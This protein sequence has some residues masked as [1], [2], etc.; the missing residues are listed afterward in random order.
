LRTVTSQ[1]KIE[2]LK[3][4]I[5]TS[6]I[7]AAA[8]ECVANEARIFVFRKRHEIFFQMSLKA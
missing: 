2:F 3:A 6:R 7:K 1:L 8:V 4:A 5:R